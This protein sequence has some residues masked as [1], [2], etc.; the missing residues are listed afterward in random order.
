MGSFGF[1]TLSEFISSWRSNVRFSVAAIAENRCSPDYLYWLF[2]FP[3]PFVADWYLLQKR[4]RN[5][6]L[7]LSR[8]SSY[9]YLYCSKLGISVSF[10]GYDKFFLY[11][12][13]TIRGFFDALWLEYFQALEAKLEGVSY[14]AS[15]NPKRLTELIK[16]EW[17]KVFR[18]RVLWKNVLKGSR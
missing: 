4:Y 7:A 16:K 5:R 2:Q 3:R 9:C 12:F 6:F 18:C 17:S 1:W 8:R 11:D 13:L 15:G 14:V 10:V